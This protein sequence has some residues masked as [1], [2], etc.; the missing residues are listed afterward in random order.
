MR[1]M[2]RI[3]AALLTLALLLSGPAPA[4]AGNAAPPAPSAPPPPSSAPPAAP[5]ATPPP[6]PA[7]PDA[8][9]APEGQAQAESPEATPPRISYLH[10]EVSFWRPGAQD[11]VPASLNMPL[12]PGDILYAGPAGNVEVQIG[13]RAFARAAYGA[14]LGLDNQEPDFVQ[15]RA[16]SGYVAV[17]LRELPAGHA[18]ELGTPGAAFTMER[19]GYYHAEVGADATTFRTHRGGTATM[20]PAGGAAQPVAGNQQATITT[21]GTA[22]CVEL[23]IAAP[24]STWDR[25]NYQRSDYLVQPASARYVSPGVYGAEALD[26]A[27]TWRTVETYG[28]VWVPAGVPAGWSP[29]TTGRWIWDPR[30]GWTWLDD[31]PWGWAP[32]HYGRWVYLG[33]GWAWAP[34]PVVVRPAYAPAL[35]VFLGGPVVVGRPLYWAP[36]G[37][38]EPVIRWWGPPHA[39]GVAWWGGWGGPRVVN[40]VVINRTTTVNVTHI[41]TYR[42]VNV[43]NAVVGVPAERFGQGGARPTR[44]A[45]AEARQLAPVRGAPEVHP[46]AA[47]LAPA[48]AAATA[49]RPPDAVRSRPVVTTRAPQDPA[50][51][52]RAQGLPA[53]PAAVPPP[54]QRIVPAPTRVATPPAPPA[55]GA[56]PRGPAPAGRAAPD[57]GQPSAR[58]APTRGPRPAGPHSDAVPSP[59]PSPRRQA[60]P[61]AP[62]AP[63]AQGVPVP[64]S[65]RPHGDSST[66]RGA[67]TERGQ[68][69]SGE[70]G[71][72]APQ[73]GDRER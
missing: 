24:L 7:A 68:D 27:G 4:L 71:Q 32:Y 28:S 67:G 25:W 29:Y 16:T 52:L 19:A 1:T 43:T 72:G 36:L 5:S 63:S 18:V 65:E 58:G 62:P 8:K 56:P 11:W 23:T 15:L 33:P 70:R 30:F 10:G 20:T 60:P 34:G 44:V 64:R 50:P 49:A 38:G 45:D 12:A 66:K 41:T 53:T 46:V 13:P 31:A 55:A 40:N 39:V 69:R 35:V 2:Q 48:R 26:R 42:N 9:A 57:S 17:D 73:R 51:T 47:S 6:A 21:E 54:Q 22:P 61:P 37:W 59:T 14:Q 3:F